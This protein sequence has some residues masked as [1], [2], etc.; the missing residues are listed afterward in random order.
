MRWALEALG[1]QR[2]AVCAAAKPASKASTGWPSPTLWL[3]SSTASQPACKAARAAAPATPAQAF[4]L[5]RQAQGMVAVHNLSHLKD[6]AAS[7]ASVLRQ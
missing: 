7:L 2:P 3:H 4:H 6:L 1:C 5:H